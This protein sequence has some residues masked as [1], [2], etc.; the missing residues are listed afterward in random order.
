MLTLCWG[1]GLVDHAVPGQQECVGEMNQAGK[2][3][4][5]YRGMCHWVGHGFGTN[6][7][8]SLGA[9][10]GQRDKCISQPL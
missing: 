6:Q 5:R 2:V 10:E 3:G 7:K 9:V 4:E 1:R 8:W